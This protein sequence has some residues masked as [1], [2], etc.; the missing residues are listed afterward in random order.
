MADALKPG[1][2]DDLDAS[3]AGAIDDAMQQQWQ[4]AKGEALPGG[5]GEQ[6]RHI[7]FAAI[8]RGVLH[9]LHAHRADLLTTKVKDTS[10]GH[11]HHL[12]FDVE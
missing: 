10:S 12:D 1:S 2:F 7:L 11:R 9:F 3:L 4:A 6:D 8:A 5:P